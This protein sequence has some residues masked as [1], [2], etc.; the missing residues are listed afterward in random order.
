MSRFTSPAR[1]AQDLRAAATIATIQ[2]A[3]DPAA[4]LARLQDKINDQVIGRLATLS[5]AAWRDGNH[6][7]S[8]AWADLA[9]QASLLGGTS[10]GRADALTQQVTVTLDEAERDGTVPEERLQA[11]ESAARE[12]M[13][14]YSD[15]GQADERIGAQLSSRGC[16]K[17]KATLWGRSKPSSAGPSSP[18]GRRIRGYGLACS[19]GSVRCTGPCRRNGGGQ[20]PNC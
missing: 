11:A 17:R 10:A 13:A 14:I 6:A 4:A 8:R 7:A 2:R 20:G 5:Y 12:A 9:V 16:G 1:W 18:R 19:A 3:P 15:A